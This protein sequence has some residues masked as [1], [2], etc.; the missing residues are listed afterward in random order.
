VS[1]VH[2]AYVERYVV[3]SIPALALL[4]AA[5]LTGLARLIAAAGTGRVRRGLAWLPTAVIMVAMAVLLAGP[6]QQIRRTHARADNLRGVARILG[7]YRQ[8]GDVIAFLPLRTRVAQFAYPA[9][10]G[11]MRNVEQ[12]QSPIL[13]DTLAGVD[14]DPAVVTGR[15]KE[16]HRVWVLRWNAKNAKGESIGEAGRA[17]LTVL[18]GMRL[19]HQWQTKSM[20]VSLYVPAS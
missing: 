4:C 10:F 6:Q 1:Q 19:Q 16:A 18:A 12:G 9:A 17:A 14:A 8:H 2:I 3:V 5:G 11:G 7:L 20:I 15:L 13:S